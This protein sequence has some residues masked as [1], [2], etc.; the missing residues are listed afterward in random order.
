MRNLRVWSVL[1]MLLGV[2]IIAAAVRLGAGA[3]LPP[4]EQPAI[5]LAIAEGAALV[6]LALLAILLS[7]PL[8]RRLSPP[9]EASARFRARPL[10]T[11]FVISFVVLFTE[12]MLIRYC[13]SQI[14]VFS[15]YKNVPLIGCFVGLG[16]G[17][18]LGGGRSRHALWFLAWLVPLGVFLS[19][20]SIIVRNM[21]GELAAIGSAEHI[22]GDVVAGSQSGLV[23]AFT[24]ALM[25]GFCVAT[26]VTITLL[27]EQLGR[28][29]GEAFEGVPRIRGYTVN[30]LG[31]LAGILAFSTASLLE[32]PPWLW[33][34][35]GLLPL[36]WWW[37]PG[38]SWAAVA[39]LLVAANAAAVWPS[40]GETVW[41][42]YQKLVGHPI[43]SADASP[44]DDPDA[45]LVQISDVFYQVAVDLR[46]D[47][48]EP[49]G[50]SAYPHYDAVYAGRPGA[51]A[52]HDRGGGHRQRRR[53][54]PAR[55]RRSRRCG[56]HRSCHRRHGTPCASRAA[57]RRPA[58]PRPRR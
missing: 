4:Y 8:A 15:F 9:D 3:E 21:L 30:I 22:L 27:F 6:I 31:S 58:G 24:Q 34:A 41:S 32:T 54:G 25:A 13:S 44:T 28:L 23:R 53:G 57:V 38:R 17:C 37:V 14:R 51:R 26:L 10:T 52:R 46:R 40:Y 29:M 2:V 35:V 18:C 20:G 19:A 43:Q 47:G 5:G 36:L 49:E 11:L 42:R 1:S 7:R 48:T 16:L 55:R 56:R 45:Y 50:A 39:V 33:F 12:L